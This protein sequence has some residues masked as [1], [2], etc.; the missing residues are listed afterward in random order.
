MEPMF[1]LEAA[2]DC[3]C[4][5]RPLA[6]SVARHCCSITKPSGPEPRLLKPVLVSQYFSGPF[7]NDGA[8]CLSV[9][10]RHFR[11]DPAIRDLQ[12]FYT[13]NCQ[14]GINDR[15]IVQA[16]PRCTTLVPVCDRG[17]LDEAVIDLASDGWN[18]Q[19]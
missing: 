8:G 11:Q 9:P 16:H 4:K 17:I 7:A 3:C 13:V 1:A 14:R 15:H 10:C 19:P 6:M 5:E 18:V 12:A 2:N